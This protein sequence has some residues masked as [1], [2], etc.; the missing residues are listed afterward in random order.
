M[1]Q[2]YVGTLISSVNGASE[3]SIAQDPESFVPAIREGASI[4]GVTVG[5]KLRCAGEVDQEVSVQVIH[6]T[7]G[8]AQP[9]TFT[10]FPT[11]LSTD[12]ASFFSYFGKPYSFLGS[13]GDRWEKDWTAAEIADAHVIVTAPPEVT[14]DAVSA[15]AT[16]DNPLPKNVIID[17]TIPG[18]FPFPGPGCSDGT[19]LWPSGESVFVK[20]EGP[21][22]S[23]LSY[24][25]RLV[26][27]QD[28]SYFQMFLRPLTG[29]DMDAC[30][31]LSKAPNS[32][33]FFGPL[34]VATWNFPWI[35]LAQDEVERALS[36][37]VTL[38]GPGGT[39]GKLSF[40]NRMALLRP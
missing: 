29:W 7:Q 4:P 26:V 30:E 38:T 23:A 22:V 40:T 36:G 35:D 3:F 9:R 19:V 6:P 25:V 5:L 37:S 13:D 33:G 17:P 39:T 8:A 10:V 14:V 15:W 20:W 16:F 28:T 1:R 2:S 12:L 21:D 18:V 32:A 31:V 11:N 34:Y 27:G 24:N